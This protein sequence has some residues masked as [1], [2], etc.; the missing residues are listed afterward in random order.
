M[1]ERVCLG[2]N[3]P[4]KTAIGERWRCSHTLKGHTGDVLDLAWS[5]GDQWLA[6]CSI[7]NTVVV[8]DVQ[9]FPAITTVLKGHSSLVKG[10]TWDPVG[11][12]LASQSDDKTVKV[13][14]TLDWK[15]EA[16]VS[17]PFEE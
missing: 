9:K 11:S 1:V 15:L 13:W 4:F 14:K 5:P 6:S 10:V 3:P 7:D 2:V 12:Y 17:K 16:T 8:W